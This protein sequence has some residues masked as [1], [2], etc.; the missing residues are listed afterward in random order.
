MKKRFTNFFDK[1]DKH[2]GS[3][4]V[5]VSLVTLLLASALVG[6]AAK[7]DNNVATVENINLTVTGCNVMVKT[8]SSN[9]IGSS[10][11]K[12]GFRYEIDENIHKLTAVQ[13]GSTMNIELKSTGK[14]KGNQT[15]M[16][17]IFIPEQQY[18]KITVTGNDAGVS[19][20]PLNADIHMTSSNGAM[21]VRVLKEFDKT[22]DFTNTDGSGSLVLSSSA[23][24]YTLNMTGK[25]SAISVSPE[26]PK[27]SFQPQYKYVKGTGKATINLNITNSA[28]SL[29]VAD[30][31]D[32]TMDTFTIK[33]KVHY[34]VDNE[35]QL[36]L[37][38]T[39]D[40]PMSANYMLKKDIDL[41]EPWVPIGKNDEVPFTGY[42]NGNGF[43]I[44]NIAVNDSEGNW[45]YLGFFG[46]VEGGKVH[47]VTLENV[48]IKT[49]RNADVIIAPKGIVA[50]AVLDGELSD[51]VVK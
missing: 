9:V 31:E 20:P 40:Y 37:I 12:D 26:L 7:K 14:A 41:K 17:I 32:D 11:A 27:Y 50:A 46:L 8:L 47:N 42:F 5:G 33:D 21:S 16:A 29:S 3:L 4:R 43:T 38:G 44:K 51:C 39:E 34:L 45:K 25:N 24:H 35:K 13:T 28:F 49:G 30:I 10:S 15:D 22:I 18:G 48:S 19:I 2:G 6:F 36:R 23:D 1:D